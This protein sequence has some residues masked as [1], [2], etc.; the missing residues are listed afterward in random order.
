V[1]TILAIFGVQQLHQPAAHDRWNQHLL[2]AASGQF[3]AN[4][5]PEEAID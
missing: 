4:S 5:E 1:Q 2:Q 3:H